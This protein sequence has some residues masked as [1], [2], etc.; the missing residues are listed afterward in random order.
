MFFLIELRIFMSCQF[1]FHMNK[2]PIKNCQCHF[3]R[4]P[5]YYFIRQTATFFFSCEGV[6]TR[7]PLVIKY[8]KLL[9]TLKVME[10]EGLITKRVAHYHLFTFWAGVFS[11][12]CNHCIQTSCCLNSM[13]T[14]HTLPCSDF[15]AICNFKDLSGIIE[16]P[17]NTCIF[18]ENTSILLFALSFSK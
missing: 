17:D 2:Y 9:R 10:K 1:H 3:W 8:W 11:N 13:N 7:L 12:K 6:L 5:D 15:R 4:K 14:C 16:V 18:Y